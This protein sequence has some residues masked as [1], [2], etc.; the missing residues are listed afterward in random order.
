M[1][2]KKIGLHEV[3][4]GPLKDDSGDGE[5]EHLCSVNNVLVS[6]IH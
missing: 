4:D 6:Q 3:F 5:G 2:S 1:C